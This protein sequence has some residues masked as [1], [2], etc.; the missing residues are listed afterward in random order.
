[1]TAIVFLPIQELWECCPK[2][3]YRSGELR[4]LLVGHLQPFVIEMTVEQLKLRIK[5]IR[6]A[7]LRAQQCREYLAGL[8][9][10]WRME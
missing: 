4:N 10:Q 6:L 1:M 2:F 5:I 3:S 8:Q 9:L 7:P